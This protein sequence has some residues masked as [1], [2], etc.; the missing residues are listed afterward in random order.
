MS[1]SPH[2]PPY[3]CDSRVVRS[4]AREKVGN[5]DIIWGDTATTISLRFCRTGTVAK[6]LLADTSAAAI[7]ISSAEAAGEWFSAVDR[8]EKR[9]EPLPRK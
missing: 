4:A 8:E 5:S 7:G 9:E 3:T 1:A 6:L 2:S